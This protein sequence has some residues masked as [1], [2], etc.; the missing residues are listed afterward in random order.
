[1]RKLLKVFGLIAI[2]AVIGFSITACS[3]PEE[4]D[5]DK[6]K[7]PSGQTSF[8]DTLEFSNEQV[9]VVDYGDHDYTVNYKPYTGADVT[10]A[11]V[12][13]AI[14]KIVNGKFSFSVG[15]PTSQDLEGIDEMFYEDFTDLNISDS[16]AKFATIYFETSNWDI[17]MSRSNVEYKDIKTSGDEVISGSMTR[18][19][20]D[21]VYVDKPV[22]I[23]GKGYT[24]TDEEGTYTFKYNDLNLSL[25]KGWNTVCYKFVYSFSSTT[26]TISV[27]NPS[28]VKWVLNDHF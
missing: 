2:V 24:E 1:M 11:S 12:Y 13:G 17:N 3:D 6:D 10:F 20:V 26:E 15:A 19:S 9:Y 27:S 25:A 21:F 18:E 4:E 22:K 28:S 5:K 7:N 23:T 8:G 16:T 14:P